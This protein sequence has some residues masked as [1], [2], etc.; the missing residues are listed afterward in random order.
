M[1]DDRSRTGG[2]RLQL[3]LISLP[4]PT[5]MAPVGRVYGQ[6]PFVRLFPCVLF[7]GAVFPGALGFEADAALLLFAEGF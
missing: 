6:F 4:F 5:G 2:F 7:F 3:G 1:V